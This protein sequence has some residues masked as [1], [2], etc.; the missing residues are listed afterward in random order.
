[1]LSRNDQYAGPAQARYREFAAEGVRLVTSNYI[2]DET[3]TRLRY[4]AGP[5]AA[6]GYRAMLEASV[7]Q[8]RL[9]VAWVDETLEREGWSLLE[10]Y[11]DVVLSLTDA[12]TGAL[13]R[14]LKIDEIF[15]F[16]RDFEALGLVVSPGPGRTR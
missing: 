13:A 3:A 2:V 10:R 6:L 8:R 15:G 14:R 12:V 9:R 1:L 16:D 4:A 7:K 11:G 5:D